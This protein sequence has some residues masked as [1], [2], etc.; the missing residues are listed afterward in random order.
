ME[1][2]V[3]YVCIFAIY[4]LFVGAFIFILDLLFCISVDDAVEVTLIAWGLFAVLCVMRYFK[5]RCF[6]K[7]KKNVIKVKR[8]YINHIPYKRSIIVI[9]ICGLLY[10]GVCAVYQNTMIDI[11]WS[12]ME[13]GEKYPEAYVFVE[14]YH[15]YKNTPFDEDLKLKIVKGEIPLFIQWDRR[16]GYQYYG[17][18]LL[19]I[20]GCG[21]T[22]LSMVLC[23]L[24]GNSEWNPYRVARF[25]EEKGY[26]VQGEGTSWNLMVSGAEELGLY[27]EQGTISKKYIQ[28]NLSSESPMICSMLPGDFTYTGHF[29]VLRGV[30]SNGNI[31]VNDPNS[32][33]NSKKRWGIDELVPQIR[34]VWR[35]TIDTNK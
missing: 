1:K 16:W 2:L 29:I 33:Q 31:M 7:N 4:F 18:D 10:G 25:S 13:F 9:L 26:Y 17:D 3:K 23:G 35:Y 24:T 22:C 27:S 19:G 15:K 12:L 28:D 14:E 34:S 8:A 32:K 11:P 30:D 6:S 5:N 20:N 21:P